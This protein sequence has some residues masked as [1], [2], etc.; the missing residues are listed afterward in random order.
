MM[1]KTVMIFTQDLDFI[2][3]LALYERSATLAYFRDGSIITFFV[4][5]KQ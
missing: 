1:L 2:Y 4:I 3:K 5:K